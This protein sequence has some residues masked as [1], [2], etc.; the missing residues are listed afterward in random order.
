MKPPQMNALW[1]EI[2]RVGQLGTRVIFR[3]GAGE[4]PIEANL[5]PDLRARFRYEKERSKELHAQD[6]SAI[7]GGFHLYVLEKPL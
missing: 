5:E 3:T 1:T 6:R 4:S 7:Y 2:A